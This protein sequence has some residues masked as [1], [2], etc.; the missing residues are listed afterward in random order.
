[1]KKVVIFCLLFI[2]MVSVVAAYP[3]VNFKFRKAAAPTQGVT[4]I[5]WAVYACKP[6]S[7]CNVNTGV[8]CCKDVDKTVW[9]QTGNSGTNNYANIKF[10]PNLPSSGW[11]LVHFFN[12]NYKYNWQTVNVAWSSSTDPNSCN[13]YTNWDNSAWAT[14]LLEQQTNCKAPTSLTVTSK[15]GE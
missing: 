12:E 8:G 11:Y 5:E 10:L 1:M 15:L 6:D 13:F 14:Q 3:C 4:N 7:G 9:Y 2:L